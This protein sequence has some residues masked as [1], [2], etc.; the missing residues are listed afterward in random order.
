LASTGEEKRDGRRRKRG[1]T[2]GYFGL[3]TTVIL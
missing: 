1:E 3:T 2:I